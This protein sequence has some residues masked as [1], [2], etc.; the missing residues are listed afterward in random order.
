MAAKIK[1]K[2]KGNQ[3]KLIQLARK[4]CVRLQADASK[5]PTNPILTSAQISTLVVPLETQL[6][7][8]AEATVPR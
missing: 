1:F 5:H 7:A 8:D 3:R 4:I 2:Y 6:Q